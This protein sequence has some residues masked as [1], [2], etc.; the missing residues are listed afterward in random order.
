MY[1]CFVT[2]GSIPTNYNDDDDDGDGDDDDDDD[3]DEEEEEEEEDDDDDDDDDNDERTP[4]LLFLVLK[5]Q[6]FLGRELAGIE[7]LNRASFVLH[8]CMGGGRR[9][10]CVV[11]GASHVV[12]EE[13][14]FGP[15]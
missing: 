3:D 13:S 10:E 7:Y 14:N 5:K 8:T 15:F 9:P 12:S 2:N 11:A 4:I 1:C 6:S